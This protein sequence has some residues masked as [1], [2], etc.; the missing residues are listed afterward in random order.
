MKITQPPKKAG[1]PGWWVWLK[2][3]CD[4]KRMFQARYPWEDD[5]LRLD[6]TVRILG[7]LDHFGKL[8]DSAKPLR[9]V[10]L[11]SHNRNLL[12]SL[13]VLE[14]QGPWASTGETILSE[15]LMSAWFW[16]TKRK[17]CCS[18]N[19]E[20]PRYPVGW[21]MRVPAQKGSRITLNPSSAMHDKPH[22]GH[23]APPG[24][25]SHA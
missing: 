18:T 22:T 12:W 13:Y 2:L 11:Q 20:R 24:Q 25:F 17:K 8:T 4:L 10:S 6:N 1:G 9:H 15:I 23:C 3:P 7:A 14:F 5:H 16:S 21:G 19:T